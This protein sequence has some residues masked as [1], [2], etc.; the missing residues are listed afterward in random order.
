MLIGFIGGLIAF[1]L[2]NWSPA[3][4]FMGDIGSTSWGFIDDYILDHS[5]YAL[6]QV[7]E[8]LKIEIQKD[9]YW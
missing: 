6:Y 3:K 1:L 7:H 4:Y 9:D 5:E 8:K 2:W